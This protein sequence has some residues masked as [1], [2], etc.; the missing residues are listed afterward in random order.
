MK[1]LTLI[2]LLLVVLISCKTEE[3]QN[4]PLVKTKVASNISFI[5]ATL[6]GEVIDEGYTSTSDRGFFY[7]EKN[8]NPTLNDSKVQSGYG[9]GVYFSVL[10]KLQENTKYYFKAYATNTK[11]TSYGEVQNFTTVEFKLPTVLTNVPLNITYFSVD[12]NGSVTDDGGSNISQRGFCYGL[13]PNPSILDYKIVLGVGLG[14]F[15]ISLQN[16]RENSK[17]YV[18]A[19]AINSKGITYGNEQS[20]TTSIGPILPRDTK[21]QV[22]EVK[23]KTGRIWMDRNLGAT[24]AATSP[25]DEK[26]YGDLYQWGR[27]F[28]G[29]QIRTSGSTPIVSNIDQPLNDNFIIPSKIPWDWRFPQNA[30]LWQGVNGVNN[31]CPVGFRLPTQTEWMEEIASWDYYGSFGSPLKLQLAGWRYSELNGV[32]EFIGQSGNYWS[33]TTNGTLSIHLWIADLNRGNTQTRE[34]SVG[35]SVRCIKD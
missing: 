25:T 29:H 2:T 3:P 17:Y 32:L 30:K 1:S 13:N 5:N 35:L 21:T 11:G 14:I 22:V 7:S 20:F 27:G 15:N 23:S 33:S 4:Y 12:F 6:N 24:Q 19:Y 16:L 34:R 28:D 10:E 18:R 9:K 26:A 31:V 8:V